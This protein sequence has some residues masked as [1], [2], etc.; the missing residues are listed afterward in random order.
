MNANCCGLFA[1]T[2]RTTINRARIFPWG[3]THRSHGRCRPPMPA[4]LS[5]SPKSAGCTIG[6]NAGWPHKTRQMEFSGAYYNGTRTHL[7]LGKDPPE[8]RP[9]QAPDA[10]DIVAIPE[11]GGLHHRYERRMAA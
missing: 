7:A 9:V 2:W 11:V 8:S 4:R 1:A 5:P 6:T 3:R 10:G